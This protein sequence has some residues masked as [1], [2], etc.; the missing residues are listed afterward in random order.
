MDKHKTWV[1]AEAPMER[2]PIHGNHGSAGKS[3]SCIF[4]NKCVMDIQLLMWQIY[5][6]SGGHN[7]AIYIQATLDYPG[8]D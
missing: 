8:A 3:A 7:E 4:L 2:I 5:I 6:R 1:H